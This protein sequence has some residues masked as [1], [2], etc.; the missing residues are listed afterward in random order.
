MAM[1]KRRPLRK[2]EWEQ[3]QIYLGCMRMLC[4]TPY[5]LDEACRDAPKL[6]ELEKIINDLQDDGDHKIIIFSE[7]TRMLDLVAELADSLGIGYALHTGKLPQAKRRKEIRRFKEDSDCRLFLSSDSG[8]TGLNLQI[9]DVVINLDLPWNPAKLEQR[10]A[11]AWRKHQPRPV[12]VINLVCEHTIEHRMLH[13]LDQKRNLAQEVVDGA[14]EQTT[15]KMPSGRA[16]FME[17]MESLMGGHSLATPAPKT[18]K[19]SENPLQR[20][21]DDYLFQTGDGLQLLQIH[22]D[23]RTVVAVAD[24]TGE[25]A[26]ANLQKSV[27]D[28]LP[29]YSLELLERNTFETIQR[30]IES[31]VLSLNPAGATLHQ[32]AS[33]E[34][35][36]KKLHDVQLKKARQRLQQAERKHEMAL[37]LAKGG[38]EAEAVP[39]LQEAVEMSLESVAILE[40]HEVRPLSIHCID[41]M[42][43]GRAKLPA[44]TVKL[45]ARLREDKQFNDDDASVLLEQGTTLIQHVSEVLNK[46]ALL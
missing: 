28:N 39:P 8:S 17:R 44:N 4:D 34:K 10:I 25:T 41:T 5:I 45:V 12:Q 7:W 43:S 3:L 31:G 38:F 42:L 11:R 20:L 22:K 40:N 35:S 9:A 6:D 26:H 36:Q 13:L 1:A 37:L 32:S 30:L 2:E 23:Q 27:Q 18:E 29:G 21:R 15:M 14:G 24:R 16:A 33:V 46:A 19:P